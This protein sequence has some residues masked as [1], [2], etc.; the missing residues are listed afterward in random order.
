MQGIVNGPKPSDHVPRARCST[1]RG[2]VIKIPEKHQLRRSKNR[3]WDQAQNF[4][5]RFIGRGKVR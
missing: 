5:I 1:G 3:L 4:I 2:V